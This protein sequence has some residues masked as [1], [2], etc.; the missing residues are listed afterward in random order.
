MSAPSTLETFNANPLSAA[1][2]LTSLELVATSQPTRRASELAA[3]IRAGLNEIIQR[4]DLS[5][6]AYGEA[7]VGCERALI[8]IRES[9][10]EMVVGS[11]TG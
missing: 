1:A 2:A 3:R 5:A 10:P 9:R 7:S 4:L 8:S 11:Q 6:V